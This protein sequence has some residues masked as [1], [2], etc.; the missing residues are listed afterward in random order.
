M[1]EVAILRLELE[2]KS[3]ELDAKKR[4]LSKAEAELSANARDVQ[5]LRESETEKRTAVHRAMKADA[6]ALRES[7]ARLQLRL[8]D[9]GAVRAELEQQRNEAESRARANEASLLRCD[10]LERM[11]Q[12]A[13]DTG[14]QHRQLAKDAERRLEDS[15]RSAQSVNEGRLMA[16]QNMI[17][18]RDAS[19]NALKNDVDRLQASM[20]D[21]RA[22]LEHRVAEVKRK[23]A[24]LGEAVVEADHVR[25]KAESE[26][27]EKE[28]LLNEVLRERANYADLQ[29]RCDDK[30]GL[31]E[32]LLDEMRLELRHR[33]KR[34]DDLEISDTQLKSELNVMRTEYDRRQTQLEAS[35]ADQRELMERLS[36][37]QVI[38]EEREVQ[39]AKLRI[40]YDGAR[41]DLDV[42]RN[43]ASVFAQEAATMRQSLEASR[44]REVT[45]EMELQ[46]RQAIEQRC[47]SLDAQVRRLQAELG[48]AND[49][50][51]HL[52]G[53]LAEQQAIAASVSTLQA[54]QEQLSRNLRV[55][56]QAVDMLLADKRALQTAVTNE[57]FSSEQATA[58]LRHLEERVAAETASRHELERRLRCDRSGDADAHVR[59]LALQAFL[60]SAA[61]DA[62]KQFEANQLLN[63]EMRALNDKLAMTEREMAHAKDEA[64]EAVRGKSDLEATVATQR[65][66]LRAMDLELAELRS[67]LSACRGAVVANVNV[68]QTHDKLKQRELE[69]A[70]LKRQLDHTRATAV[71]AA[72][73]K[74]TPTGGS[75]SVPRSQPTSPLRSAP[76][77]G[78]GSMMMTSQLAHAVSVAATPQ[79]PSQAHHHGAASLSH[80]PPA[81][82]SSHHNSFTTAVARAAGVLSPARPISM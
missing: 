13:V 68:Q 4:A 35:V 67:E 17:D 63:S 1:A 60:D 74:M 59:F 36:K 12:R 81:T 79:Q 33:Q 65:S 77:A 44:D 53:Q 71:H 40:V 70:V 78:G 16:M 9:E 61:S 64:L 10:E 73:G 82:A 38:A 7:V 42:S 69:I 20:T 55:R 54:S 43:Q 30:L 21:C 18:Q 31:V 29:R 27:R 76:V 39:L 47:D 57:R 45:L 80:R 48:T 49:S 34:V 28:Q 19:I 24:A 8:A 25:A 14:N 22:E 37:L 23:E 26:R 52:K 32:N 66:D 56:E 75:S 11:L 62:T 6:D 72:A 3:A 51:Q 2:R 41:T 46:R 5:A 50:V 15:S 58:R